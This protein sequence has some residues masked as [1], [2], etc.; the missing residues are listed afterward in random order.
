M[1]GSLQSSTFVKMSLPASPFSDSSL[2]HDSLLLYLSPSSLLS[3]SVSSE[4]IRIKKIFPPKLLQLKAP[5]PSLGFTVACLINPFTSP[6]KTIFK[7]HPVCWLDMPFGSSHSL[8]DHSLLHFDV[9]SVGGHLNFFEFHYSPASPSGFVCPIRFH[10]TVFTWTA[11]AYDFWV[12]REI[13]IF[14]L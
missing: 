2:D 8:N 1:Q 11:A 4:P 7:A 5:T 14:V 3:L 13:V 6:P 9:P 10:A 12:P